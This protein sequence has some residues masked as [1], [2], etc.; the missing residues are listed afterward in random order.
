MNAI[1]PI[2]ILLPT[3]WVAKDLERIGH[4]LSKWIDELERLDET[5]LIDIIKVYAKKTSLQTMVQSKHK[6]R[7]DLS[8]QLSVAIHFEKITRI[9]WKRED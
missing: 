4:E 8:G 9:N 5:R 2:D 3:L 6:E 7:K 1:L